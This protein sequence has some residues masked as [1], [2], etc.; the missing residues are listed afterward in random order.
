MAIL[1]SAKSVTCYRSLSILCLRDWLKS[2]NLACETLVGFSTSQPSLFK[3][4]QLLPVRDLKLLTRDYTVRRNPI[5]T[6]SNSIRL[7]CHQLTGV[8]FFWYLA[9]RKECIDHLGQPV[10]GRGDL[11]N[12]GGGQRV[13]RGSLDETYGP[14]NQQVPTLDD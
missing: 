10:G 12:P 2:L 4:Q 11:E 3:R 5:P 9:N 1:R 7:V 6:L 14:W 13:H 8:R